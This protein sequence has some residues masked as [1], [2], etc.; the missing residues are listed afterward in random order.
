MPV[1]SAMQACKDTGRSTADC[2]DQVQRE[3]QA[4]Q[5]SLAACRDMLTSSDAAAVAQCSAFCAAPNRTAG[6]QCASQFVAQYRDAQQAAA[7]HTNLVISLGAI[8][9]LAVLAITM[10]WKKSRLS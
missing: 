7:S 5:V 1:L 3:T 2:A 9:A 4:Q 8:G 10:I 6:M